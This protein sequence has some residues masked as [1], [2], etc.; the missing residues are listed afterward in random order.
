MRW[1]PFLKNILNHYRKWICYRYGILD[2]FFIISHINFRN[3]YLYM[4]IY[5][6]EKNLITNILN[7]YNRKQSNILSS[8][9]TAQQIFPSVTLERV[10]LFCWYTEAA[11]VNFTPKSSCWRHLVWSIL[12]EWGSP[13]PG[14]LA[15]L[16]SFVLWTAAASIIGLLLK[17]FSWPFKIFLPK[18][19][20]KEIEVCRQSEGSDCTLNIP[21]QCIHSAVELF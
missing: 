11:G 20:V 13:K 1:F 2:F 3:V 7:G 6:A 18:L 9:I 12:T 4:D 10:T 21:W 15:L 17:C 19:R 8:V 14:I 5:K 16:L